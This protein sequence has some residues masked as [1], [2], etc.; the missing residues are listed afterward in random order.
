MIQFNLTVKNYKCFDENGLTLNSIM[1]INII[2][3]KN[4]S[5]KSSFI[6]IIKF[7]TLKDKSFFESKR[8]NLTTEVTFTHQF[9]RKLIGNSF[10]DSTSGGEIGINH[11]QYG[12]SFH[13]AQISYFLTKNF[14][15]E[16]ATV[17]R[18]FHESARNYFRHYVRQIQNPFN[19]K[20]FS[21]ISA[22]RDIIPEIGNIKLNLSNNGAGA[23]DYIQQIINREKYDSSLIENI[24]LDTLNLIL[25]PDIYFKRILV[26]NNEANY[27]EIYF[28]DADDGRV[29]LSKMGS[30]VKTVLL[31]LLHLLVKPVIEDKNKENF[32]FAFEELENNLHP[33]LQRRLYKYIYDYAEKNKSIFFITTHS[34][35]VIDSYNSLPNTQ[36]FHIQKKNGQTKVVNAKEH[37]ELKNLLFDLDIKAS[38]ILQS[39]GII[40]VEGPSDRIYINKWIHLKDPTLIEG[41]H[42]SIMFYGG[43]LLS[44]LTFSPAEIEHNLI[45]LL[46]LNTNAFV[47][48]D[49]DG[50]SISTKL[51]LT[52]KRIAQE[53]G[54]SNI[55]ITKGREIENYLT[56]TAITKWIQTCD[57]KRSAITVSDPNNHFDEILRTNVKSKEIKYSSNKNFHATNITTHIVESDLDHLD[58]MAKIEL[59]IFIIKKWNQIIN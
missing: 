16:F 21:H 25:N 12:E 58:L 43:R 55:W 20:H 14:E 56:P 9:D 30:G 2:I 42:Y 49:R 17:N 15:Y 40:W 28:D 48:I 46:H 59:L 35:I 13:G 3:G 5:G 18:K 38:D 22:E 39:N 45:P 27:W 36:L 29:P 11:H 8:N 47:V 6:D 37:N 54:E 31:V 7:I 44:N 1:P 57:K 50:A 33:A 23:T 32:I 19:D 41:Y 51:N 24:L 52:K 10:S 34:N 53:I 4:N 26:Q